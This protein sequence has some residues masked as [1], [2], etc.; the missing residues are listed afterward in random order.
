MAD[1]VERWR[2]LCAQAAKE[3]DPARL[4][5][6]VE[7]INDLLEKKEA[8]LKKSGPY[9]LEGGVMDRPL[10]A[11]IMNRLQ[12]NKDGE[13]AVQLTDYLKKHIAT[14]L[15]DVLVELHRLHKDGS[16]AVN[17]FG[18]WTMVRL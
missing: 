17:Q 10:E 6:L 7:E 11:P 14:T 4:L 16:V 2:E 5:Q 13:T 3:Q 9:A 15:A 18:V 1:T 12:Q 8:Q